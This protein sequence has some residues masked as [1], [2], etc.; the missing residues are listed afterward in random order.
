MSEKT[1]LKSAALDVLTGFFALCLLLAFVVVY[2]RNDLQLFSLV[3][4]ALFFLAGLLRSPSARENLALR[5][6]LIGLGGV[7]PVVV[8]KVTSMAF[9]E[10][11]YVPLFVAFSLS[12]AMAGTEARQLLAQRRLGTALVLSFASLGVAA[13]AVEMAIPALMAMWS[14]EEVDRPAPSFSFVT[15][16]GQPVSSA[17]LQGRVIV[18]AFWAT[19][20]IPCRQE[21]PDIQKAYERYKGDPKVS[22]YAVGGPWGGDTVEKESAFAAQTNLNLPLVFDADGT[23]QGLGVGTFPALIILDGAGHVRMIHRGYDGSEHLAGQ[24]S[25]EIGALMSSHK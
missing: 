11:G 25:T 24:V 10:Q 2:K 4:A 13:I 9:T 5:T 8:M 1:N 18:L 20:C 12:L 14:S 15:L 22:F 7:V 23:A 17:D 3:T 21:L 6:L 16:E 19:W